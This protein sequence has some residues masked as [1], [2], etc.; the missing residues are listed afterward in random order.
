MS[1]EPVEFRSIF[2]ID[3]SP[4]LSM[5]DLPLGSLVPFLHCL[6]PD[7]HRQI[8]FSENAYRSN[9]DAHGRVHVLTIGSVQLR[10]NS[11]GSL[12]ENIE[13]FHTQSTNP[14]RFS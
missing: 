1:Y 3:S 6:R 2:Y 8:E 9:A 7:L 11:R 12:L 4:V 14:L 13:V 5:P 10:F